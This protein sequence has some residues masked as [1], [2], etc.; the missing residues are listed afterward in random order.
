M[1]KMF[2]YAG[3]YYYQVILNE[4]ERVNIINKIRGKLEVQCS[5]QMLNFGLSFELIPV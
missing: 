3:L 2:V 5:C 1:P 4:E